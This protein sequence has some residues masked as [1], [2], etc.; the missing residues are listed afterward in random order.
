VIFSCEIMRIGVYYH[1]T[2]EETMD[3]RIQQGTFINAPQFTGDI[4]SK[5]TSVK[6]DTTL[7]VRNDDLIQLSGAR[8]PNESPAKK[9]KINVLPQDPQV[10]PPVTIDFPQEKIGDSVS[11]SKVTCMDGNNPKAIPDLEGNY[12]YNVG[13]PQFDQVNAF[14]VTQ[15]TMDMFEQ[16]SG[17]PVNFAFSSKLGVVPH[18]KEGM[19]AYYSRQ[20]RS[21]NFFYFTSK[22]LDKTVQ[23]SESSDIVAHEASH[24]RLDG[25]R[26]SY[27]GWDSE[28]MSTHEAYA[29]LGAMLK[30]LQDPGNI[31]LTLEQNG[32]DFRKESLI[33]RLGEEFGIAYHQGNTN[34]DDD[35]MQYLRSMLNTFKYADPDSLP[36]TNDHEA[37][38]GEPHSFSRILSGAGY[39]I[40]DKLYQ[41]NLSS[42]ADGAEALAK[43]RDTL[44][45]LLE[46]S[47]DLAPQSK[48]K[49]K[50]I[51]LGIL[52]ADRF[53]NGGNN[54][55][56]LADIFIERNILSQA[57]IDAL[58]DKMSSL[59]DIRMKKT[60][61]TPQD[62][63]K[64]LEKHGE[65][66][67]VPDGLTMQLRDVSKGKDGTTLSLQL[68]EDMSLDGKDFAQYE[69]HYVDVSGGLTL[70]FDSDGRLVDATFDPITDEKKQDVREGVIKSIGKD[71]I[72]EEGKSNIFKTDT[73]IYQG[74]V[75]STAEGKKKI[76]RIPVIS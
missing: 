40:L 1:K 34:P 14:Y 19:N 63:Q 76:V 33:S 48:C 8:A 28:T 38:S 31:K 42:S 70:A 6:T 60:P 50:D 16:Y 65:S 37:L 22:V 12:L 36:D 47:V 46:K 53:K 29:D 56:E 20:E 17:A 18:K 41:K 26:P 67:G 74:M 68:S 3:N 10:S 4:T 59:P 73:D 5:S 52:K 43:A 9:I 24:C 61:A 30:A 75:V 69:G 55:R 71:L 49:Y 32:G 7:E 39:D 57:D 44:G 2:Q 64:F 27:L 25:K 11:N 54:E 66:L 35:N 45:V 72:M 15:S 58:N 21:L 62:V 23:T 51:A 13:T